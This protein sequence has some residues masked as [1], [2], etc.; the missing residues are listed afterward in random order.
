VR[1][2][3]IAEADHDQG[4]SQLAPGWRPRPGHA[5]PAAATAASAADQCNGLLPGLQGPTRS[6]TAARS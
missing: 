2:L 3:T 1:I 4:C 6:S 5:G